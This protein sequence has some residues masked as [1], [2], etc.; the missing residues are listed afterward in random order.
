[1]K[2]KK[3]P[4]R[5]NRQA[6]RQIE[7]RNPI[8]EALRAGSPIDM[9]FVE[10]AMKS[11]ERLMEIYSLARK[12]KINL[13]K[14]S[15]KKL[16]TYSK[17]GGNHQGIIAFAQEEE[18]LKINF[19]YENIIKNKQNP[20]FLILTD[21][22]YEQNLG[23]V[24]RSAECAGVN[25]VIAP[26]K[27]PRLTPVVSRAAVGAGEYIPLIH[28]NLFTTIKYLKSEGVKIVGAREGDNK[29]IY[30]CD[31][32]KPIAILMGAEDTGISEPLEKLV[33]ELISIPM[34]GRI[35]SLNM[36]VAAALCIYE[37]VRQRKYS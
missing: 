31:F 13:E 23:A 7:G 2:V 29:I 11:D 32:T 1:M 25:A 5:Y 33:D 27:A 20:F 30:R 14:I 24:L 36:S 26:K 34:L 6:R 35:E 8:R 37:V 28:E 9:I 15:S 22:V 3:Q 19:V 18:E 12:N 10:E 21:V 17:T 16:K 4:D